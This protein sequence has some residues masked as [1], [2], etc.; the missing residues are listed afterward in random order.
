M[1]AVGRHPLA[2]CNNY[3]PPLWAGHEAWCGQLS[4]A[5]LVVVV[6]PVGHV[7][8]HLAIGLR[9]LLG[10]LLA[11]RAGPEIGHNILQTAEELFGIAL[12]G[13]KMLDLLIL[14]EKLLNQHLFVF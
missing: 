5:S 11:L 14:R 9:Q 12:A 6:E 3:T 10:G 4:V 7:A 1:S 2:R 8:H 13:E